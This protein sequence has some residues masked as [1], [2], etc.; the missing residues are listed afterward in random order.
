MRLVDDVASGCISQATCRNRLRTLVPKVLGKG[1][2]W[3]A[4]KFRREHGASIAQ[5]RYS[6]KELP[7]D[8]EDMKT[9]RAE[10]QELLRETPLELMAN[11]DEMWRRQMRYDGTRALFV[12][13]D[14]AIDQLEAQPDLFYEHGPLGVSAC[15]RADYGMWYGKWWR[16]NKSASVE[17]ETIELLRGNR[18]SYTDYDDWQK[19][20]FGHARA[21]RGPGS[22][23]D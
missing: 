23:F 1:S 5:H 15:A 21:H 4:K 9:N 13:P 14:H 19:D 18:A 20:L 2:T 11:C 16:H 12:K 6:K 7:Y 22:S 3:F 17:M 10:V 8:N